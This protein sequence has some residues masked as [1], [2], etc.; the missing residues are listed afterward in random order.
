MNTRLN[1]RRQ[2]LAIGVAAAAFL[3]SGVTQLIHSQRHAGDR[4]IGVAGHVALASL[5][6]A[7]LALPALLLALREYSD[8][9]LAARRGTIVACAGTAGLAAVRTISLIKGKDPSYFVVLGP[10][11]NAMWLLGSIALTIGLRRSGRLPAIITYGL[12]VMWFTSIIAATFGGAI[13]S[14]AYIVLSARAMAT[15]SRPARGAAAAA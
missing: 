5:T 12:P 9:G 13:L 14:A 3:T 8:G 10:L 6:V 2:M 1:H 4:V 7:L 11:T 15:V